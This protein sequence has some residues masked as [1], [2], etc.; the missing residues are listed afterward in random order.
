MG[1]G[2]VR[3]GDVPDENAAIR[4]EGEICVIGGMV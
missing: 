1:L 4:Q 3:G 2:R